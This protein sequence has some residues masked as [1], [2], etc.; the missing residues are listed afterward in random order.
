MVTMNESNK[1]RRD[2]KRAEEKQLQQMKLDSAKREKEFA[3]E[4]EALSKLQPGPTA[5]GATSRIA[6]ER[7]YMTRRSNP[8]ERRNRATIG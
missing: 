2:A 1:A 6:L 3:A 8:T 7:Q 5:M 4:Q